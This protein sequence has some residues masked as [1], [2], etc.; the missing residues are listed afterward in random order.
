MKGSTAVNALVVAGFVIVCG[1]LAYI[2]YV[3]PQSTHVTSSTAESS[4]ATPTIP[5]KDFAPGIPMTQKTTI[6]IRSSDSSEE[7]YIVPTAQVDT[8]VKQLPPGY[9]VVSKSQ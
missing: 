1:M 7:K 4:A 5:V 2:M 6:F 8:Y 3:K 9:H